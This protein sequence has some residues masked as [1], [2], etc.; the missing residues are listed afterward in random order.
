MTNGEKYELLSIKSSIN[1]SGKLNMPMYTASEIETLGLMIKNVISVEVR[2]YSNAI[3]RME[4]ESSRY[5]DVLISQF[6]RSKIT[7]DQLHEG[8][9]SL[10]ETKRGDIKI[11]L[12]RL[13]SALSEMTEANIAL[14][15]TFDEA[16]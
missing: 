15:L 7:A 10:D 12:S 16:A 14:R 9:A 4:R 13:Q 6:M 5:R 2:K 1:S 11:F 8:I 3:Q